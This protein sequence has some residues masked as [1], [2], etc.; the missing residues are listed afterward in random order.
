MT[1]YGDKSL[2]RVGAISFNH[3]NIDHGL[4]AAILNDYYGIA[5]RNECFCAHPYVSTL[6]KEQLWELDI[7]HVAEDQQDAFINRK[8][9]MVRVSVSLYTNRNDIERFIDA[10]NSI[11][12]NIDS[13][14]KE[15]QCNEDG[16]YVHKSFKLDCHEYL[17]LL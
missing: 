15:Y 7:E 9:G 2:V 13:L 16:S 3:S 5:V 8:R 4:F 1:V 11:I 14:S 6:I 12:D 17:K 10:V